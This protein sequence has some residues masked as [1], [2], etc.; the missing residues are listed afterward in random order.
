MPA[1][2]TLLLP[3]E[4]WRRT[5]SYVGAM[6]GWETIEES[7][8]REPMLWIV[9]KPHRLLTLGDVFVATFTNG[10]NERFAMSG[11][12]SKGAKFCFYFLPLRCFDVVKLPGD[13]INLRWDDP[14]V[15]RFVADL[16]TSSRRRVGTCIPALKQTSAQSAQGLRFDGCYRS[17]REP[18]HK[19][20]AFFR[21]NYLRFFPDGS[22]I[23]SPHGGFT[24]E[25]RQDFLKG[26]WGTAGKFTLVEDA[27]EF[28]ILHG[29]E[30]V[31]RYQGIVD[32]EYLRLSRHCRQGWAISREDDIYKFGPWKAD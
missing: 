13:L 28:S 25:H 3:A 7:Y 6:P 14:A 15:G 9:T 1:K 29:E 31:E 19:R 10:M 27:I 8:H 20:G 23:A 2:K 4:Q 24:A 5:A 21:R 26:P 17:R 18:R 22:V 32:G 16:R 11:V 30:V 12:S